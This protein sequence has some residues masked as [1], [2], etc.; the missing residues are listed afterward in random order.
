VGFEVALSRSV[1]GDVDPLT[2]LRADAGAI[3]RRAAICVVVAGCRNARSTRARVRPAS[4][5]SQSVVSPCVSQM[6]AAPL[7]G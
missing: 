5:A 1:T 7:A 6:S 3:R 2:A 4:V